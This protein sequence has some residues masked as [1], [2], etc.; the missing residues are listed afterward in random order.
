LSCIPNTCEPAAELVAFV[1]RQIRDARVLGGKD[2][3]SEERHLMLVPVL[4]QPV[5][6]QFSSIGESFAVATRDISH[7]GIGLVHSQPI[8]HPLVSLRMSLADVEVN[9]VA[10]VVWCKE[11]GPYYYIG[12]EFVAKW[13]GFPKSQEISSSDDSR[14]ARLDPQEPPPG[15]DPKTRAAWPSPRVFS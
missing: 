9:V 5:D 14:N 7:K 15:R 2:R 13:T 1:K 10:R 8:H 11:L 6:E 12:C 4:V 3:R